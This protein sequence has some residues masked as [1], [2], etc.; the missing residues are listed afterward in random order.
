MKIHDGVTNAVEVSSINE[1]CVCLCEVSCRGTITLLNLQNKYPGVK[2]SI[3]KEQ[4]KDN[5]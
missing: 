5:Q 1:L 2:I 3:R 4:L